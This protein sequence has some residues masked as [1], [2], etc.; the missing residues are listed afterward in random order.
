MGVFQLEMSA[1]FIKA[2]VEDDLSGVTSSLD[3]GVDINVGFIEKLI[4]DRWVFRVIQ[5]S[6]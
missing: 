2:I 6:E 4:I 1:A 3:T 5:A